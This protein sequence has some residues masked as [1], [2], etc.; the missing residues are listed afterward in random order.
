M[1]DTVTTYIFVVE[2]MCKILALGFI[3][4]GPN[5]YLRK[6][7]FFFDFFIVLSALLSGG[8]DYKFLA[9]LKILRVLRVIRPL[10]II[11][12]SE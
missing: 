8:T 5:S 10:R 12:R 1:L 3:C 4:N 6:W 7:E 11:S 2:A 9:Q